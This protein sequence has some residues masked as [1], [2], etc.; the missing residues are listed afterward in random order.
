MKYW[1]IKKFTLNLWGSFKNFWKVLGKEIILR[2]LILSY[3]V[4]QSKML[5]QKNVNKIYSKHIKDDFLDFQ[6]HTFHK[7]L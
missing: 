1:I 7:M 5:L 6:S 2:K 3:F 4:L